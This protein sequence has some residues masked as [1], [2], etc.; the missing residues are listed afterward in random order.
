[1]LSGL[2]RLP[3]RAA[4]I[5]LV[6]GLSVLGLVALTGP[7]SASTTTT[8]GATSWAY[9][10]S[11]TPHTSFVNPAGNAPVGTTTD[12]AGV[13][14]TTKSYFTVDLTPFLGNHLLSADMF[15]DETS[16]ADCTTSRDTQVW[17]TAPTR[18][19]TWADQ[20]AEL[21]QLSELNETPG[22]PTA[23][24]V[25][26]ATQALQDAVQAGQR[27]ATFVLRLPDAEQTNPADA[28]SYNPAVQL[29][30]NYNHAPGKPTQLSVNGTA[31]TDKPLLVGLFVGGSLGAVTS[32]ADNDWLTEQFVFWPVA[33]PDQ[34]TEIDSS[35]NYP[36]SYPVTVG[37]TQSQFTD[38][39]TYAWHVRSS[40]G[41][42]TGQWS[43]T[44]VFTTDFTPPNQPTVSS[45][46]YPSDGATHGGTGV[47]GAFTFSPDGSDDVVGYYY[48]TDGEAGTYVPAD[49]R[50][51]SATI[52]ITP[53]QWGP[54]DLSVQSEDAAGN[55]SG[56]VNYQFDVAANEPIASCTPASGY[57]GVARQ[58]TFTPTPNGALGV[59]GYVYQLGQAPA[60]T[61]AAGADGSAT[62][63]ITP[64]DVNVYTL[65]VQ[66]QLTNGNLTQ[67]N[68]VA[69][70]ID[71][72]TPLIDQSAGQ[73]IE[74]TPVQFTFHAVLPGSATF[75]YT[76]QN[77]TPTTVPVGADG[78]ATVS[79]TPTTSGSAA[80]D[81]Y[82]TTAS[83]VQSGTATD[84]VDVASNMPTVTSTQYPEYIYSGG[85]SEPG[86]FTFSSPVPGVLSYT[87][88]FNSDAPVTVPAGSDGTASV[89]LTP[90]TPYAQTL[91]V[92]STLADGTTS[93]QNFYSFNANSVAPTA[94]CTP[95]DPSPGDQVQCTFQPVQPNVVSYVYSINGGAEVDVPAAADGTATATITIPQTTLSTLPITIWSVNGAGLRSDPLNT[96]IPLTI[97]T[98][99]AANQAR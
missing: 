7:A 86:T 42:D 84:Y 45:T 76:W 79:L 80:L 73:A 97:P 3:R 92:T 57:V 26:D 96:G 37:I 5:M 32:D 60:Q 70:Q 83:G 72:G 43:D 23:R 35:G 38:A 67:A 28:R 27:T 25:W 18:K 75:T 53:T 71:P 58:C 48:G 81:L 61:V 44:C 99:S 30:V 24:D 20:P 63:T 52:S 50:G 47:P 33:N 74:G 55:V 68:D 82:S 41:V 12:A 49:H 16:M 65:T 8:I 93:E 90:T 85:V 56:V 54:N 6:V 88:T 94:S 29:T 14:H 10:D 66:A 95:S 91:K 98:S 17:L 34:T 2:V 39:T 11:A 21:T 77:G 46:D 40:D 13:D 1:M 9:V 64:T 89:V 4:S 22:C 62:V 36:S 87:Y 51:G 19:P 59:T 15:A 31:C 78:T 69:L